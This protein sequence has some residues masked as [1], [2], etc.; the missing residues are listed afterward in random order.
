[1]TSIDLRITV[2]VCVSLFYVIDTGSI[3]S[4]A[5]YEMGCVSLFYVIDTGSIIIKGPG[6]ASTYSSTFFPTYGIR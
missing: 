6:P 1:M 2:C 3:G 5:R 4:R